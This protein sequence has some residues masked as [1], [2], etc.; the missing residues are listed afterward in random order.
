MPSTALRRQLM[1]KVRSVVVKVGTALLTG[2]DGRLDKRRIGHIAA[3][4]ATLH[5][6][7]V[8]VTLVSSGAVG[9]GIGLTRQPSRPKSMPALQATA[10]IGQPGL[11]A[12]YGKALARRGIHAGQVLVSRPDFEERVRYVNI[13]NT[14]DALHALGAIPIINE[15]DTIAIEELDRFAD[16]D[17]ISALITN[18]LRADL[19]VI[20]T[21]VDGLLDDEGGLVDLVTS[22]DERA[23]RLIR[24]VKSALGSGGMASK[25]N[26]AKLVTDAGEGV[27]IANGRRQNVL[28]R[29]LEGQR[30]GT[31]FAPA[32]KKLSARQRWLAGAVRPV[33]RIVVD[34]GAAHA[35]LGGGKS[36]LARGITQVSGTFARGTIVRVVD[37]GGGTIAHGITNFSH[38]ELGRIKG[39]K[40]SEF[41]AVLGRPSLEEVIHRDN[42][43]LTING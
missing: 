27:V 24:N 37:P 40:S 10:A 8:Q 6:R 39:L 9:A 22:V 26:A 13:R 38:E 25:L 14:L 2:N 11:M 16:N 3:Q 4:L 30:V 21:V 33:G 20:L 32:G 29:L 12:I 43:V 23:R 36:L 42:L 15:N 28:V 18:L 31:I 17:M 19:L 34:A 1:S 41:A 5:Q 7:G 35:L